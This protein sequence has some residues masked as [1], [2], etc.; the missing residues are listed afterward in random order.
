MYAE[1]ILQVWIVYFMQAIQSASSTYIYISNFLCAC[2]FA[3]WKVSAKRSQA[4]VLAPR[5]S[6][7][8]PSSEKMSRTFKEQR[9]TQTVWKLVM[10][11]KWKVEKRQWQRAELPRLVE[12]WGEQDVKLK[13]CTHGSGVGDVFHSLLDNPQGCPLHLLCLCKRRRTL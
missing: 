1:S 3:C 10:L 8:A 9:S 12:I 6:H 7:G 2:I 11:S 13:S 4:F 5:S